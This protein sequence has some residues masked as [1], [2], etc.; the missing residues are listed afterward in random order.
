MIKKLI[1]ENKKSKIIRGNTVCGASNPGEI[2]LSKRKFIKLFP[3]LRSIF[4]MRKINKMY[5]KEKGGIILAFSRYLY[6]GDCNPAVVI[7]ID[8]LCVASYAQDIDCVVVTKYP[9]A[10]REKFNL[11]IGS[12]LLSINTYGNWKRPQEDIIE[13]EG[14]TYVWNAFRT[15][16]GDFLS[17]DEEIIN[18]KKQSIPE[19]QW[20]RCEELAL[21]YPQ[22]MP[23]TYRSCNPLL[24]LNP[25]CV[26]GVKKNPLQ[27]MG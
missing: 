11:S 2:V 20:K 3:Q 22:I 13:G 19:H 9:S 21:E 6:F 26:K 27:N 7:S 18:H 10:F 17:D 4:Y 16:I 5:F 25:V 14:S 23:D 8:P 1:R 24:G 15:L 12:R